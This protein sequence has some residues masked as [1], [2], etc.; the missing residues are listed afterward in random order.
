MTSRTPLFMCVLA[1]TACE[2]SDPTNAVIQNAYP[3]VA[4]GGNAATQNVVYRG[5]WSVTLFANPGAAGATADPERA[6]ASSDY[7]YVVLAPGWDPGST[8]PPT[9][10]LPMKS[11]APVVA[12]RGD[13]LSI[14]VSDQT[15]SGNCK[16]GTPL[17]QDDADFIASRI[18]PGQF[19]GVTYDAA[20]CMATAIERDAGVDATALDAGDGG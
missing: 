1:A 20:H 10:L 15:F 19:A 13:T 11:K 17:S 16:T 9:S 8:T 2:T 4:N 3:P 18:F 7:A 12:N 14:V 5:W 6:V